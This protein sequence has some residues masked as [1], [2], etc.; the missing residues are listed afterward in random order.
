MLWLLWYVHVCTMIFC[1]N[2]WQNAD[3]RVNKK[4]TEADRS[5]ESPLVAIARD[6]TRK[7][8][9]KV[10]ETKKGSDTLE[11]LSCQ[12]GVSENRLN[13]IVPNGFA[14]HYPYEK[15]LFHWEY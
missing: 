8:L 13:P 6:V 2:T 14:D 5:S 4:V 9:P 3:T 7:L 15:W 1:A 12:M 10:K 11:S